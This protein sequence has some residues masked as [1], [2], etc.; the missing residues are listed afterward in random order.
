MRTGFP[1]PAIGAW[2][3]I[4]LVGLVVALPA[5]AVVPPPGTPDLSQMVVQPSDLASGATATTDGYQT[6]TP[7]FVAAYERDFGVSSTT[8]GTGLVGVISRVNVAADATQANA[9]GA[10]AQAAF[11]SPKGR[12]AFAR[13]LIKAFGRKARVRRRSIH[14]GAIVSPRVGDASFLFP[15]SFR[16]RH[17]VF[18][19]DVVTLRVDRIVGALT[20]L[21]LPGTPISQ[22]DAANVAGAMAAHIRSGLAPQNTG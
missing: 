17:L 20:L 6:P 12:A 4:V 10:A 21:S 13:T 18:Y 22:T 9:F 14:F 2:G 3:A 5:S 19:V 8:S 16:V 11:S 15:F 1:K 7:P